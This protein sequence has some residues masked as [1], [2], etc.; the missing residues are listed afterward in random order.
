MSKSG[1]TTVLVDGPITPNFL[2]HP[3]TSL[4]GLSLDFRRTAQAGDHRGLEHVVAGECRVC[5]SLP[6]RVER[7]LADRGIAL[8]DDLV[9][10]VG[11]LL[12]RL[13]RHGAALPLVAVEQ[14]VV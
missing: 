5:R 10:A 12:P 1:C 9:I 2:R 14:A 11:L 13:D 7:L 4:I 3:S 8:A 6:Q